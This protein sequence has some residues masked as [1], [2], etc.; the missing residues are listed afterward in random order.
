MSQKRIWLYAAVLLVVTVTILTTQVLWIFQTAR[1]EESFINHRVNQALC[2]AMDVLSK[3]KSICSSVQTCIIRSAGSFELAL[4]P[5]EKTKIDSVIQAELSHYHINVPFQTSFQSY[6]PGQESKLSHN[7]VLLYPVSNASVQNVLV[8]IQIPTK[9]DLV[10]AQINGT[11]LLSIIM[12]L[13]LVIVFVSVLR[14]LRKE[15]NI[16]K[17][18]VDLVNTMAH[19]LKTPISN[20][21][22]ALT[23]IE[24]DSQ[25]LNGSQQYISIINSE[26]IKLK[27]RAKQI[28]GIATVDAMLEEV[29]EKSE[30]NMHEIIRQ[31][32]Q[33]FSLCLKQSGGNIHTNLS[34]TA[35]Y[36][37]GNPVQLSTAL[38]NIVDNA[39]AYA[40]QPPTI[41]ITTENS[42]GGLLVSISD[43]GPGISPKERELIF[44]KGYRIHNGHSATEGFGMGLYLAKALIEK[45]GGKLTL[46]SSH[47]NGS[48]FDT[49]LRL[50]S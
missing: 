35:A 48:K 46:S 24:K 40:N 15:Y 49:W 23:M 34:A 3:D 12:L 21:S 50:Q 38:T 37:S 26:T 19:D 7:Q 30:V 20:I 6:A 43:N 25:H 22:L 1:L 41:E 36:V 27:Q 33:S 42:A 13:V 5:Q 14:A 8:N 45:Q 10:R 28:L 2:S 9:N 11:F 18:T 29:S 31:T 39:I 32:I 16:R 44:K 4:N 47:G 17:E